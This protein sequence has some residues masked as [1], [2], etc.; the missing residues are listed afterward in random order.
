MT[1]CAIHGRFDC[2]SGA[3]LVYFTNVLNFSHRFSICYLI[4]FRREGKCIRWIFTFNVILFLQKF[5]QIWLWSKYMYMLVFL[6]IILLWNFQLYYFSGRNNHQTRRNPL[7]V[8]VRFLS[9]LVLINIKFSPKWNAPQTATLL[10][11]IAWQ[12]TPRSQSPKDFRHVN[13]INFHSNSVRKRWDS[14]RPT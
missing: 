10:K 4:W 7:I 3:F 13:L 11:W 9:S 8:I 6:L 5:K 2:I 1:F 14:I 12:S